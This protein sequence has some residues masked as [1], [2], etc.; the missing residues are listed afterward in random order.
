M[1]SVVYTCFDESLEGWG[2]AWVGLADGGGVRGQTC[3]Q[4]ALDV[5]L[6]LLCCCL[7][8][9]LQSLTPLLRLPLSLLQARLGAEENHKADVQV[10][11]P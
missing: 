8:A 7:F 4:G 5:L 11:G 2:R 1:P 3:S 10:R 6:L 9:L